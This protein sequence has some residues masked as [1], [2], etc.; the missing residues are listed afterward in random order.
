MS[1]NKLP[2]VEAVR[3]VNFAAGNA[4]EF[5]TQ[6]SSMYW[7]LILEELGEGVRALIDGADDQAITELLESLGQDNP[8]KLSDSTQK[9]VEL[10][11]LRDVLERAEKAFKS[12]RYKELFEAADRVALLDSN[13]DVAVVALGAGLVLGSDIVGAADEVASSNLSKVLYTDTG[14]PYMLKDA[15]GKYLKPEGYKPPSLEQYLQPK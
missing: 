2:F 9:V 6:K 11:E 10:A 8:A 3:E 12:G 1:S 13:V 15:N 14:E 7:G 4:A 5:N